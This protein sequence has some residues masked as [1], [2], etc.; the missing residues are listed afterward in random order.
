MRSIGLMQNQSLHKNNE[1]EAAA[2]RSSAV[3]VQRCKLNIKKTAIKTTA[4][5]MSKTSRKYAGGKKRRKHRIVAQT[6]NL[7]CMSFF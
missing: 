4:K 7:T 6:V 5:N 3:K 2:L 1:I